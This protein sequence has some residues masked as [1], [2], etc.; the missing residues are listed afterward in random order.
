MVKI[1][2]KGLVKATDKILSKIPLIAPVMKFPNSTNKKKIGESN[3]KNARQL[4]NSLWDDY[5]RNKKDILDVIR[6]QKE[7]TQRNYQT[8]YKRRLEKARDTYR[9]SDD[10]YNEPKKEKMKWLK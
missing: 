8:P 3:E 7:K 1:I 9:K 4:R 2:D 5:G 10:N 6:R